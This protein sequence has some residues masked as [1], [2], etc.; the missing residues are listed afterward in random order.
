[1]TRREQTLLV[2]CTLEQHLDAFASGTPLVPIQQQL[3]RP[4][5]KQRVI[6]ITTPPQPQLQRVTA[7]PP[8]LLANNSTTLRILQ[9]KPC[10]HLRNT[11]NNTPGA[12]PHINHAHHISMLLLFTLYRNLCAATIACPG[13]HCHT[14]LIKL[15]QFCTV[16][17]FY[18]VR[19]ISQKAINSL[20]LNGITKPQ[21]AF[22]PL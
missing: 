14:K 18:N 16:T 10:T 11:R 2:P 3:I 6:L 15:T 9:T 8:T 13:S 5:E 1:V 22:T 17:P 20:I 21:H 4:R 7:A 12:L 19:I